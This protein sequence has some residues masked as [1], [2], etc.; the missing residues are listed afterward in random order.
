MT[1]KVSRPN[2]YVI[3]QEVEDGVGEPALLIEPFHDCLQISQAG[4]VINLNYESVD[5]LCK[6]LKRIKK[7]QP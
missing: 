1:D 6:L 5:E 2:S 3:W 4:S 7:E